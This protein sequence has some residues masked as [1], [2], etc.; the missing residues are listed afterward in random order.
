MDILMQN[1]IRTNRNKRCENRIK[2]GF[3]NVIIQD[4]GQTIKNKYKV[5]DWCILISNSI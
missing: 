5:M 2:D 4:M 1:F 3:F